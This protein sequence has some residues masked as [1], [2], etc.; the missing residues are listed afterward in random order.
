MPTN[1]FPRTV[2]PTWSISDVTVRQDNGDPAV[3]RQSA[4]TAT[5]DGW[6]SVVTITNPTTTLASHTVQLF[7][8]HALPEAIAP[9]L[10]T[11]LIS[12]RL[13]SAPA[14]SPTHLGQILVR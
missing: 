2:K 11:S 7:V 3:L 12:I 4:W 6:T 9:V 1:G 10:A 8:S 5:Q 14:D 13:R